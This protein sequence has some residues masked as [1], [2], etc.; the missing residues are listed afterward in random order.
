MTYHIRVRPTALVF[1]DE[2]ILLVEYDDE[3]GVHYNLPGG[4]AEPGES[5]VEGALRELY[6][7]TML[8]AEAG[9]V[10]FVYENA[11]HKQ[12][13]HNISDI[14]TLYIIFECYPLEG[15]FPK[16]PPTPDPNQSDVKWIPLSQ[17]DGIILYPNIRNH[18]K[19]Y[20]QERRN[21]EIIED[22]MLDKYV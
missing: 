9:P 8:E 4:G 2:Q 11:P 1:Q 17:L 15:A 16:L 10:A 20:A 3:N 7:E 22:Y 19:Q 21:I 14:H 18:I 6:E 12:V 5:I 13:R